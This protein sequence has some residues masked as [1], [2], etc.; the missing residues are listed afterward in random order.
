MP[1]F[2]RNSQFVQFTLSF[3]HA[4]KNAFRNRA[5]ILIF[6]F[7]AF[8]R[9]GAIQSPSGID[10]IWPGKKEIPVD[11]EYSCSHPAVE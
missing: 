2:Y 9:L 1:R 8:R 6:Q 5:K 7:L 10:Q 11:Q 3:Q 4:G